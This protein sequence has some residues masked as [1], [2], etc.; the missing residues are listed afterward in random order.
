MSGSPSLDPI[1]PRRDSLT[2]SPGRD[3]AAAVPEM[4]TLRAGGR[5]LVSCLVGLAV[6]GLGACTQTG[7]FGRQRPSI[8]NDASSATGS[9]AARVRGEPVSNFIFTDDEKELRDRAFRFLS[10]AHERAWFERVVAELARTG[11]LPAAAHPSDPIGYHQALMAGPLR[12]PVS[13][14]RRLSEDAAADIKLIGPFEATAAK[15]LNSDVIRLRS[16]AYV[17]DLGPDQ[18]ENAT[19]RVT[20][21]RCLIAWVVLATAERANAYR[22]ALERLV[23]EAPQTEA[24]PVERTL[25]ALDRRRASLDGLLATGAAGPCAIAPSPVLL[26]ERQVAAPE[27]PGAPQVRAGPALITK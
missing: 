2:G 25:E 1:P 21:N 24:V 14:Y 4:H 8:W 12:S 16:L 13:R 7:D 23:I 22:Y 6:V 19:A 15:V 11:I 20:E 3:A 27:L 17:R 9:L 10:P 5:P 26:V 18:V